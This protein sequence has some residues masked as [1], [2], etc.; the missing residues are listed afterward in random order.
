MLTG[1]LT[2]LRP[3]EMGDLERCLAWMNDPEV[4]RWISVRYPV[5][6]QAEEEWL[7]R[8]SQRSGPEGLSLAIE[9]LPEGRH[10]G[11]VGLGS[12][13]QEDRNAMLG[14]SI[15]EKE[16][17]S[18]GYGTDAILTLLRFA[19]D[20]MN[21]HRVSLTVLI[22]NERA[23]AC[24]RKCGFVEEGR[25]RQDW[26]QGGMYIDLPRDGRAGRGVPGRSRRRDTCS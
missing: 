4:T 8:A 17:W 25:L 13:R 14:V 12:L 5:S 21:L 7:L 15:G 20:E 9:T 26:F 22:D 11:T 19:F 24:Y 6:R 3:V 2:R 18:R 23:I 10:I 16:Y 1:K